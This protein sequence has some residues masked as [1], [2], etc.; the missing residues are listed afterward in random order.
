MFWLKALGTG[1]T[2]TTMMPP[3]D[4]CL[5]APDTVIPEQEVECIK[6]VCRG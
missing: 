3:K 6:F 2:A 1:T 5:D 4:L